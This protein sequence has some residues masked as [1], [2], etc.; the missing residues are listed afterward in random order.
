MQKVKKFRTKDEFNKYVRK[1]ATL[2]N[3]VD[4]Y[5]IQMKTE[6]A[7]LKKRW[8]DKIEPETKE[9]DVHFKA[10]ETYLLAHPELFPEGKKSFKVD[11][12]TVK[13][14]DRTDVE[15][16]KNIRER[17]EKAGFEWCLETTTRVITTVVNKLDPAKLAQVGGKKVTKTHFKITS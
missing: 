15:L 5:T 4:T 6:S 9:R 8:G 11:D 17:L 7:E 3:R 10:I 12:L 13:T 2:A 1:Y 16:P 14:F